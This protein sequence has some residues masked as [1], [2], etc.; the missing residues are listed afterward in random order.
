MQTL[1]ASRP[2]NQDANLIFARA[3][4][5][6]VRFMNEWI[7]IHKH[8]IQRLENATRHDQA[9]SLYIFER[10]TCTSSTRAR[11]HAVCGHAVDSSM[12]TAASRCTQQTACLLVETICM[13]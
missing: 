6:A 2:L 1:S 11:C 3:T 13:N 12:S 9:C 8:D 4:L 10:R 5:L 7:S